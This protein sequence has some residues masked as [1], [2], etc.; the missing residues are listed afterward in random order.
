V[1]SHERFR[2]RWSIVSALVSENYRTAGIDDSADHFVV[3]QLL[4]FRRLL[5]WTEAN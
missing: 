1:H 2:T 4:P 5:S 3:E